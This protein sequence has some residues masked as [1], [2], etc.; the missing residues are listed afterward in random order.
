MLSERL[1]LAQAGT[2]MAEC[3]IHMLQ[4]E[5]DN[6]CQAQ[7]DPARAGPLVLQRNLGRGQGV[8]SGPA[9]RKRLRSAR[10]VLAVREHAPQAADAEDGPE[11]AAWTGLSCAAVLVSI[12]S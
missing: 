5:R 7:P 9:S 8:R 12:L 3:D 10:S 1:T 11:R 4:E 6:S 2:R